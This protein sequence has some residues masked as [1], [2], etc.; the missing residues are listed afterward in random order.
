MNKCHKNN[1]GH[2]ETHMLT[3]GYLP[4]ADQKNLLRPL[5][6]RLSCWFWNPATNKIKWQDVETGSLLTDE[7]EDEY[8]VELML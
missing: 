7:Q 2:Y 5:T 8:G 4:M 1:I 3:P 6:A